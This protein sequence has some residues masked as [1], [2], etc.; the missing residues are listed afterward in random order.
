VIAIYALVGLT[1][2]LLAR[3][4]ERRLLAWHPNFAVKRP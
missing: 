4:L 3:W 1:S 2:D